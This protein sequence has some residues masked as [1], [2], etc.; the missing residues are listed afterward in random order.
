[1]NTLEDRD[2]KGN[3]GGT[4]WM[5][6][7]LVTW[8]RHSPLILPYFCM[9]WILP[10][11][12]VKNPKGYRAIYRYFRKRHHYG[13]LKAFWYV[14]VNYFRF[15]QIIIDRFAM[16]AGKHFQ[17]ETEGQELFDELDRSDKG[18]IQLSSHVGNYELAGYSLAPKQKSFNALIFGGETAQVMNG[19]RSMFLGKRIHMIPLSEDMSHVFLINNALAEGNIVSIPGDRFFG[20]SRVVTCSFMEGKAGFPPGPFSMAVQRSVNML[21][22]FVM[23]TS[24][25]KYHIYVRQLPVPSGTNKQDKIK[26]LAQAFANELENMI[27]MYPTQ[28]FNYFDFWEE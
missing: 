22:V 27:R 3:T 4:P 17:L 11:Y 2:W 28:W 8:F 15:G 10:F 14:Y 6:R 23:K 1:M 18:F 19:R 13:R 20:A 21:A 7:T 5:Q 24:I 9:A 16:Y 12:M 26:E 25:R